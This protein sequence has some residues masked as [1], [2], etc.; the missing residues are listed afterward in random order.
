MG[1]DVDMR[2]LRNLYDLC[3]QENRTF[4]MISTASSA[5]C[6]WELPNRHREALR[7]CDQIHQ[8]PLDFDSRITAYGVSDGLGRFNQFDRGE[9]GLSTFSRTA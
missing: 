2:R 8:L 3:P 6:S 7:V 4:L 1:C 9:S 5:E